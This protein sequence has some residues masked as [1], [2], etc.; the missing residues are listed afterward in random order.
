MNESKV[1][2]LA[3]L[4]G[5][6]ALALL[7]GVTAALTG[8]AA[9]LAE[10]LHSVADTGNEILLFLGM[11]VA[12]HPPDE[13]HPFGYGK[14]VFFWAFV[15]SVMLFT[16]GGALSLWEAVRKMVH[17]GQQL[18]PGW[19][20]G[21]LAGAFVF[22]SISLGVAMRSLRRV[23]GDR[24]LREFWHETRDPTLLTVLLE[25]GAALV[26]LVVAA[27]GL[28]VAQLTG[29]PI[30][31]AVAS[32]VIGA[33]ILAVALLLARENHSL[34]IGERAED[35]VER[36]LRDAVLGDPTVVALER[37]RTMHIG[38]AEIIALLRVRLRDELT[39]PEVTDTLQRLHGRI[40]RA[41]AHDVRARFV[42]IEPTTPRVASRAA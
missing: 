26:S 21:V 31:D 42:V 39:G 10:T 7:K 40:D 36:A 27:A 17:G 32:A 1:A 8:S 16:L 12:R 38:P 37:L 28:L 11:R 25:D 30:W 6:A 41:L 13:R 29:H 3:A 33:I 22:E 24:S 2:V 20:Y 5:N 14:N 23:Q 9:M 4:L 18:A 19:A 34:L 35:D 15:V